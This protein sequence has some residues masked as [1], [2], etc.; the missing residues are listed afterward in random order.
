MAQLIAPNQP[1]VAT[2]IAASYAM[3]NAILRHV[4]MDHD[5]VGPSPKSQGGAPQIQ[6]GEQANCFTVVYVYICLHKCLPPTWYPQVL[7]QHC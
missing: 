7:N 6:I 5:G 3:T 2:Q 1:E 4:L